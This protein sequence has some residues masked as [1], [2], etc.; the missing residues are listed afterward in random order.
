MSQRIPPA[1]SL[2]T[3]RRRGQFPVRLCRE[4]PARERA[5]GKMIVAED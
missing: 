2:R 5:D 3:G 4:K 1:R